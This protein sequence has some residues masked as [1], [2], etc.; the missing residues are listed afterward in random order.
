MD[1]FFSVYMD[2]VKS[3]FCDLSVNG[4]C[5]DW[6]ATW[7]SSLL[8]HTHCHALNLNLSAVSHTLNCIKMNTQAHTHLNGPY[9]QNK[10][11]R[12]T[13]VPIRNMHKHSHTLKAHTSN[14]YAHPSVHTPHDH[15]YTCI[16]CDSPA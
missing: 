8:P 6:Q 4:S 16:H 11:T 1:A 15:L 14:L 10:G 2:H 3:D 13:L 9:K 7:P 12:R 5:L